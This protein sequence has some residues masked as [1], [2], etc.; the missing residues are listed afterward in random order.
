[1]VWSSSLENWVADVPSRRISS[2]RLSALVLTRF[3]ASSV[4]A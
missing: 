1:L 4:S 2:R 3:C